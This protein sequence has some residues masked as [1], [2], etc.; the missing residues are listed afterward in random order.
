MRVPHVGGKKLAKADAAYGVLLDWI[1]GGAK[2][3]DDKAARMHRHRRPPRPDARPAVAALDAATRRPGDVR[4]RQRPRR[5]AHRHL[6]GVAQG[7]PVGRRSRPRDRAEARAGGGVGPLP[8]PRRIG[9]LHRHRGRDRASAG[10][11]RRRRTSSMSSSHAKL[12]QLQVL[13]SGLCDDSTFLRRVHLD[14]TGLLPPADAAKAFLAD[15]AKDKRAKLDR[16]VAG[17]AGIRPVLGAAV[18]RPDARHGAGAA[19]RPGRAVR[20][21]AH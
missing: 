19:G 6:R 1:A 17:V 18:R 12:K 13:P 14:L 3:D 9:P 8:E 5:H 21:V 11:S 10:P 20:R 2:T 15:A 7:S 4:R 16:R